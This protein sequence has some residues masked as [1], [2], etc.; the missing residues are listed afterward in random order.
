MPTMYEPAEVPAWP[1]Y[2]FVVQDSGRVAVFGPLLPAS[3]RPSRASAIDAVAAA[4]DG[5]GRPVRA[6]ATE[7]DGTVWHLVISPDGA[8]GE[9]SDGA[10]RAKAPKKR[11]APAPAPQP[12][13]AGPA[14]RPEP[15]PVPAPAPT[16]AQ[17]P[18]QAAPVPAPAPAPA[19]APGTPDALSE[20]VSRLEAH[21]AA[22]R[23]DQALALAAQ[24]DEY[25]ADALGLAHPEALRVRETRA[26]LTALAGDPVSGVRMY[27]DVAERWH[28]QGAADQAEAVA[29]RAQELWLQ[30]PD[31]A[32]AA[33]AGVAMV[34][35][36]NQ[37]PGDGGT[38]FATVLERQ[39]RLEAALNTGA[40]Q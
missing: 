6:E 14:R 33:A 1:T 5:L 10:P 3:E 11:H 28:Y 35:M 26:R 32:T 4:A 24:L 17:T 15:A 19:P 8:V 29:D 20:A 22:G 30:I 2:A 23:M 39:A 9:L 13:A 38:A 7:P 25:A 18:A 40:P 27:R 37:I 21:A 16:R 36:R 34:R 12:G 31:L